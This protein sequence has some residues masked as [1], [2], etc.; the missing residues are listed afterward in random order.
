[1]RAPAVALLGLA[2]LGCALWP[3]PLDV[4]PGH[5]AVLGRVDLAGFEVPEATLDIVREDGTFNATISAGPGRRDFALALPPGR[6]RVTRIVAVKDRA[7]PSVIGWPLRLAFEVGS[8]PAIYIGTLRV[9]STLGTT[10]RVTVVDE[11][12]DTLRT[13]RA[14][15]SELPQPVTRR[16]LT[17][18]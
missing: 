15:Y 13:L 6:Y 7:T 10:V 3:A 17:P 8:E 9:G 11:Y 2:A 1:M 14:L 4:P 12:E 16:L 18:I 5:R